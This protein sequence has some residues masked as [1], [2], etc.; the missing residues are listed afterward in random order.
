MSLRA[1]MKSTEP[2]AMVVHWSAN[3]CEFNPKVTK[4]I[5]ID[6]CAYA[7]EREHRVKL[8]FNMINQKG[9]HS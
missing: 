3:P 1:I 9:Y 6:G 7:P 8:N 2:M 4:E 5:R